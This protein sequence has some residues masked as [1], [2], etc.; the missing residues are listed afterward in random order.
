MRPPDPVVNFPAFRQHEAARK[1]ANS[2]IMGLLVGAQ[3]S[4]HFL[5]LTQG[6]RQLLPTIFPAVSHVGRFN[7]TPDSARAVLLRADTHLGTMAVPYALAIHEDFLRSC[8]RMLNVHARPAASG[9][10]AAIAKRAEGTFD[11]NAI[12]QFHVLRE[13]RNIAIHSGGL[14]DKR[15]LRRITRLPPDAEADWRRIAGRSPGTLS[16]GDRVT[17]GVGELFLTL[18]ATKHLAR[19]ANRMLVPALPSRRWAELIIADFRDNGPSN[20]PV[21]VLRR[22]LA[23]WRR[24]HYPAVEVDETDLLAAAKELNLP[25]E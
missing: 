20:A 9:L 18:S 11:H 23:G 13:L 3:M 19:Q 7:L 14:V 12:A 5:S 8:L 16:V 22:K 25:L 2:A 21:A 15:V 10:H 1:E 6:S 17:L 24:F 4:A